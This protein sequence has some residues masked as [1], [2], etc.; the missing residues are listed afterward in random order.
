M[1]TRTV[2]ATVSVSFYLAWRLCV[3]FLFLRR[4]AGLSVLSVKF[5]PFYF[6]GTIR[7]WPS[8]VPHAVENL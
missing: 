3:V 6:Y 8:Y 7:I 5:R 2:E 4:Y 1:T